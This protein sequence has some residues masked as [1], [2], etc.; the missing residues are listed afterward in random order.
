[1]LFFVHNIFATDLTSSFQIV[2][3]KAQNLWEEQERYCLRLER[4][5]TR[6]ISIDPNIESFGNIKPFI[7]GLIQ[8]SSSHSMAELLGC[9]ENER[10]RSATKKML[11]EVIVERIN[12][13]CP[14][15][16]YCLYDQ[17]D[18]IFNVIINIQKYIKDLMEMR[19]ERDERELREGGPVMSGVLQ[20]IM[21]D[22]AAVKKE[23][24]AKNW[25]NRDENRLETER[26][27]FYQYFTDRYGVRLQYV[28]PQSKSWFSGWFSN[29]ET[30]E[31]KKRLLEEDGEGKKGR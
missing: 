27:K 12:R 20:K 21:S 14:Y 26:Q 28:K 4:D 10:K 8:R 11:L 24:D 22:I 3:Y 15:A 18:T 23:E 1:M 2:D 31:D 6:S 25:F 9:D 7:D 17:S 29:D 5:K 13:G 30:S 19:S 16:N